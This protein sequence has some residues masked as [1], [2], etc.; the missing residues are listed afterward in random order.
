MISGVPRGGS[1]LLAPLGVPG[2]PCPPWKIKRK[3][4]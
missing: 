4:I 3:Q 2:G 1:S